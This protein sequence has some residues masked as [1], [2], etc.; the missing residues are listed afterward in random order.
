MALQYRQGDLLFVRQET[1]PTDVLVERPGAV[2]VAGEATGHAHRLTAGVVLK[3]PRR[4]TLPRPPG[5]H[6]DRP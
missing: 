3:S 2:I 4:H 1:Q 5:A 6:S